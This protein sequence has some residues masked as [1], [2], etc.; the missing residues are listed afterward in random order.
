M[1]EVATGFDNEKN[2]LPDSRNV[3][4][5]MTEFEVTASWRSSTK[6]WSFNNKIFTYD[7]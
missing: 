1:I 2:I 7:A 3:P 5:P 4:W 6:L